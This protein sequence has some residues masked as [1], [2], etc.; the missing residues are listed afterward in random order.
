MRGVASGTGGRPT[1]RG[2][3][4]ELL[5]AVLAWATLLPNPALLRADDDDTIVPQPAMS[6][7]DFLQ[8]G[9]QSTPKKKNPGDNNSE[10]SEEGRIA[11]LIAK[12]Q[13]EREGEKIEAIVV[14]G[15]ST[16]PT[17]A[18]LQKLKTQPGRKATA[19]QIQDD[20]RTLLR[21]RWFF[22]VE[23]K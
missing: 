5:C 19:A 11:E 2:F 16:I 10:K 13:Q 18:I 9:Q 17:P 4:R 1:A 3:F 14:E 12:R 15:N 20:L 22:T 6:N 8:N 21:T 7:R 23:P